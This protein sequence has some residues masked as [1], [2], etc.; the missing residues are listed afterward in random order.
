MGAEAERLAKAADDRLQEALLE[1]KELPDRAGFD[2]WLTELANSDETLAEQI[3]AWID[4]A[5]G[6]VVA[7]QTA[8]ADPDVAMPEPLPAFPGQEQVQAKIAGHRKRAKQARERSDPGALTKQ[9]ADLEA[10]IQ[11][12]TTRRALDEAW[13]ALEAYAVGLGRSRAL[14][15]A[16]SSVTT[17]KV[18][19][20]QTKLTEQT[21]TK[22]VEEGVNAELDELGYTGLR[23]VIKATSSGG[24]AKQGLLFVDKEGKPI[25][26]VRPREVFSE[27]EQRVL[28]LA[29]FLAEVTA[30]PGQPGIVLD[31]PVC[32]MDEEWKSR[33]A[34]RL[35]REAKNRQVIAFSHSIAFHQ[36]LIHQAEKLGCPM[37]AHSVDRRGPVAGYITDR[38][39]WEAMSVTKRL[40]WLNAHIQEA[41][42]AYRRDPGSTEYLM[43][44][45]LV[46]CRVRA[47]WERVVEEGMFSET[48][49]R[50]RKSVET[51]RIRNS[52]IA[53]A[54]E[55]YARVY[56]GMTE[57]SE[58]I[59]AHDTTAYTG[60]P[61]PDPD[62]MRCWVVALTET[63]TLIE[64]E[65]KISKKAMA[66]AIKA[67]KP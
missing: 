35:V 12:L 50:F 41:E 31:D 52:G 29:M 46:A 17:N 55:V 39:V 32:S 9:R 42:A 43:L 1:L 14:R 66:A 51:Q 33:I 6:S 11:D 27:G 45:N 67:P 37:M 26:G 30:A 56:W 7:I 61:V 65:K 60:L 58:V 53:T 16:A 8:V 54:P 23:P 47:T 20:F 18:R 22:R 3:R 15:E 21:L 38:Q 40:K 59:E 49:I 2:P 19:L 4:K 64:D 34:A 62:E 44:F 57:M 36:S 28:S 10:T 48:V 13:P 25:R 63:M 5:A 24:T